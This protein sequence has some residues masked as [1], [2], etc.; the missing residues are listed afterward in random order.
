M[1]K[2]NQVELAISNVLEPEARQPSSGLKTRIKRLLETD[3]GLGRNP[4]SNDPE[5]A[6]FAFFRDAAPGSGFE[7][8]FSTYEAFA[9]L[10]G[11]QLMMHNW[12]QRFAVSVLR[13]V[14]TDLEKE[15][16]RILRI[17]PEILFDQEKLRRMRGPGMPV[18]DTTQ[19]AFLVIV[20]H[21]GFSAEQEAQPYA[22]SIQRRLET[23]RLWVRQTTKGVGGGASMFELTVMAH[24]LE[25][26]LR[27][28]KPESRGRKA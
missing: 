25:A 6:N 22:C 9:L 1:Y 18:F 21:Y 14:R 12:P 11:L 13:R 2:R 17:D 24:W 10:L 20:S 28:T 7:V 5:K 16:N 19:P 3:R 27:Q 26:A 4:R 23:A 8:W 15:L